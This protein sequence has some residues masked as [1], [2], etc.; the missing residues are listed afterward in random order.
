MGFLSNAFIASALPGALAHFVQTTSHAKPTVALDAVVPVDSSPVH[1]TNQTA[2]AATAGGEKQKLRVETGEDAEFFADKFFHLE[3]KCVAAAALK[4]AFYDP[5]VFTEDL[6][7][8]PSAYL[9]NDFKPMEADLGQGAKHDFNAG[10]LALSEL[11]LKVLARA[12]FE[13]TPSPS[14]QFVVFWISE[15]PNSV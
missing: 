8:K 11:K 4:V 10:V 2:Q 15:N 14:Q 7:V 3:N 5:A 6:A 12:G 1:A 13:N 9:G